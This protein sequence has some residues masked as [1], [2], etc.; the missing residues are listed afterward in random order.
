MVFIDLPSTG[1]SSISLVSVNS[2][3][4][5]AVIQWSLVRYSNGPV[6][7]YV[8]QVGDSDKFTIFGATNNS[9]VTSFS[10]DSLFVAISVLNG[11]GPGPSTTANF[12]LNSML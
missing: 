1:P 9:I 10:S 5:Q 12:S 7:G 8:V 11:V 4:L 6:I 2:S 3:S